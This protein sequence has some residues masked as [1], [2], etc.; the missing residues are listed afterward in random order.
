MPLSG[1]T[2]D[3]ISFLPLVEVKAGGSLFAHFTAEP[4][5]TVRAVPSA[6]KIR[7]NPIERF[8]VAG[9]F[10]M[11]NVVMLAFRDTVNTCAVLKSRVSTF[12]EM[13]GLANTSL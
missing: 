8:A 7:V 6:V 11:V 10:E 9:V 4:H 2:N 5:V 1:E 12:A 3:R 13:L